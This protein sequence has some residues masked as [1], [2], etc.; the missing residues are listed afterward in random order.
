MTDRRLRA[1]DLAG[2]LRLISGAG[3]WTTAEL[4]EIGLRALHLSDGPVGIRGWTEDERN[5]SANL[6]SPTALAASWDEELLA[7]VGAFLAAEASA[8]DVDV[9]L[10]PTINLHRVPR[11]GR[12]FECYSEDP[13]LTGRLAA[14]YVRGV[15]AGGVA[16]CPKHYVAN[17]SETERMTLDA[18][19]DERTLRELYLAPF[20][21]VVTESRP[22]SIMAAYNGVNGAP[23]TENPLLQDPLRGEWGFDGM[24]MSDWGA[25]YSTEEP[26]RGGLDLAMPGPSKLWG[27]PLA[28][29][30]LSGAVPVEAI[31][32][33][34]RH[35]LLLAERVGALKGVP[36]AAPRP[37]PPSP[38][39]TSA[40][41]REASAA[42]MVLLRNADDVL[43]LAPDTTVALIGPATRDP[44]TQGGGSATVFA[45][46][47]VTPEQGLR[48]TWG[49]R[50]AQADG[51]QVHADL[52]PV[53]EPEL[54]EATLSWFSADGTLLEKEPTTTTTIFR[55]ATTTPP[56]SVAFE[57]RAT[58]R[59]SCSGAWRL[60]G[61]GTGTVEV[62]V[63]DGPS[64]AE[65]VPL[66]P[67][68]LLRSLFAPRA[69]STVV[70]LASGEQVAVTVRYTW[71]P[72]LPLSRAGLGLR[73]PELPEDEEFARAVEL[74]RKA[75]V[76]VV[77][78]GTTETI[79][80]EGHDREHLR[81]PGRQDELVAAVAAANPRT[82]VVVNS[83]G[84]VHMPW[85]ADVAG[86]LL[87]WFPGME[88]GNA[89]ADVL[90]G[91]VEPGG[92][93]PTTWPAGPQAAP[94]DEVDPTDGALHY[95]EGLHI[96]HRAY[97]KD[98]LTPAYWFGA[99][100][101]YTQWEHEEFSAEGRTV[102]VG[103]RNVGARPG[104]HVVQLYLSR[105]DT[106]VERPA[107]WLAG[108]ATVHAAPGERVDV[109]IPLAERAFQ[110]WTDSGWRTEPGEFTLH[111]A[112]SAGDP[113]TDTV[114]I[115][116]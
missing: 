72:Q 62:T 53:R 45:P 93:L 4:P 65:T 83:G 70:D 107:R 79:E 40:F 27:E 9:V 112:R 67:H 71:D 81:L 52:H 88:F 31:D 68:D 61:F 46:Y 78:V 56:G 20:E 75:D 85:R 91:A 105:P 39:A 30:V 111:L 101:G 95:A 100:T 28:E 19:I 57:L 94:V 36:G 33:K 54:V 43:P 60:G 32:E 1:L 109:T 5:T 25:L 116:P 64:V 6:P 35:L 90:S 110:H 8:K 104:K 55:S 26:A 89:L 24:V 13:L 34:V 2:K 22:W 66:D 77:L 59:A 76:A 92:R 48:A 106:S 73:R 23:M 58:L 98:G 37:T 69:V 108:F 115:A 17:D 11:G 63:D 96:G 74:A 3:F 41:A 47:T 50:V 16:A 38:A 103:V 12:H 87:A 86:V 44:R 80:S 15:Q 114:L 84:P 51:V 18:R 49:G 14:A 113:Q 102:R 7:R 29:A 97:L 42:G 10:G 99:G 82:V 21:H